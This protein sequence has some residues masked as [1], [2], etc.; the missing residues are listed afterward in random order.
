MSRRNFEM[1]I[2]QRRDKFKMIVPQHV[3]DKDGY[4]SRLA[5]E[6]DMLMHSNPKLASCDPGSVIL[7]A[8]EAARHRLTFSQG[9]CSL[10]PMGKEAVFILGVTG[11]M[12]ILYRTGMF[13]KVKYGTVFEN[14]HFDY[15]EG[16]GENDFIQHKKALCN[17]GE[18]IAAWA[19]AETIDGA[20]HI[21]VMDQDHLFRIR[22][23]SPGYRA[24]G[25]STYDKWPEEMFG[26]APL[27]ALFKRL[28][29]DPANGNEIENAFTAIN[30]DMTSA[31]D[32]SEGRVFFEDSET[33]EVHE[34]E[35]E[36]ETAA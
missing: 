13:K 24:G 2:A 7:G 12:R 30:A 33:G 15:C 20:H 28:Q 5:Y 22:N 31:S 19:S 29:V 3:T 18:V 21:Y 6:C 35:V 9:E 16:T 1:A 27:K 32:P 11:I 25:G 26:K 34:A 36:T 8:M 14:D 4:L 23:G 10:V 17:R